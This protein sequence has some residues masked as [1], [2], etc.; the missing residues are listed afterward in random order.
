MADQDW[1]DQIKK[2]YKKSQEAQQ[3]KLD[4]S[5]VA[6][7]ADYYS[8]QDDTN[9]KYQGLKNQAYTDNAMAERQRKESMA[10]MGLSGA[11]GTSQTVQQSDTN[12][13]LSTLGDVN[14]QQQDYTD[15]VNLALAKLGTQYGADIN[16]L[17]A[18]T[19]SDLSEALQEQS[20][21]EKSYDIED[22]AQ[23]LSE[24]DSEFNRDK[25]LRKI[26]VMTKNQFKTKWKNRTS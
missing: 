1:E 20:N 8:Q 5:Y 10:N 11:G 14:R 9:E 7:K 13:L 4:A 22:A 16:S 2:T 25:Y 12:N 19:E 15:N 6:N 18:Q 24:E 21:W 26:G 23:D 17:S 3:A